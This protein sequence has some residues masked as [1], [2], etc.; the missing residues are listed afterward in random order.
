MKFYIITVFPE[1]ITEALAWGVIGRA[2]EK[3]IFQCEVI[4]PR[5]FT[6][7]THKT[8]DDRP[9]GGGDGMVMLYEP[10]AK[11]IESIPGYQNMKKIFMSPV[12]PRLDENLVREIYTELTEP[13]AIQMDGHQEVLIL[14]GR[15]G[16]VDQRLLNQFG[17]KNISI[18]DYVVSGG[19]LPALILMD[20][21]LRKFPGVL[22]NEASSN[23]DSFAAKPYF[24]APQFTR[25][26]ENSAGT[27]PDILTSGDHKK[28][29]EFRDRVGLALT[30]Q[31]RPDLLTMNEDDLQKTRKFVEKLSPQERQVLGL[32]GQDE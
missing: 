24:E 26:R 5:D 9:F 14:S 20:A 32:R 8:V 23:S 4:N 7:D 12:G 10:L 29:E 15:Y 19:E 25:P 22:G 27:V 17:F 18:G 28:I 2:R 21:I 30:L 16:G 3:G 1:M 11:A 13:T 31:E 6:T